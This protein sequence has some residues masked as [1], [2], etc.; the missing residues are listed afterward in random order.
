[1]KVE[2]CDVNHCECCGD[3]LKDHKFQVGWDGPIC[4]KCERPAKKTKH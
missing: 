1:M 3:N 4:F 2:D